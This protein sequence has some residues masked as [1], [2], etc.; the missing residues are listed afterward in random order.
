MT[1]STFRTLS[2]LTRRS[3]SF[4]VLGGLACGVLAG[5]SSSNANTLS[6]APGDAGS[7]RDAQ[8]GSDAP[9]TDATTDGF[10]GDS[11]SSDVAVTDAANDAATD[12]AVPSDA[13]AGALAF[14]CFATTAVPAPNPCPAS[15]G[16]AGQ[17]S[18][19]YRPQWAGVTG[20]DVYGGFGKATDWTA[21]FVT[22]NNDGSGMFTATTALANGS[23]PYVF[24]THGSA[25][26][27]VKDRHPFLDQYNPRFVPAPAGAPDQRSVSQITVPQVGAPVVH[28]KGSVLFEGQPQPCYSIDLEAGENIVNGKVVSEHDT[29]NFT[30][31]A[32]DGTF[33]FAVAVGVPYGIT[34]RYPFT[35]SADAGYP[36]PSATPSVGIARA[37]VTPPADVALDP[38]DVLYPIADYAAMSPTGGSA[39]LPVM[40]TFTVI[41]GSSVAYMSVTSTNIAGND[42]AYA[43]APGTATSVTWDGVFSGTKDASVVPGTE[44]YWGAWQRRDQAVDGGTQWV[45]EGLLFPIKFQ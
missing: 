40:V 35:L 34:I 11:S 38:V 31:S 12:S 28:I 17:A 22:L 6:A 18:F 9:S 42:P 2:A 30:E 23:Y 10:L 16:Q 39:T 45:E 37:S 43:S 21:P 3:A 24:E 14:S 20:V 32:M 26:N 33:D 41:P 25:D 4:V 44:Y 19:C 7:T 15:S 27:L 29:A 8:G 5:C 36:D 13:H 1:L